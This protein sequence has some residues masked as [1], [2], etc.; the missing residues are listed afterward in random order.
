MKIR[1]IAP[2]GVR[3]TSELKERLQ[4]EAKKNGRSLNAEIVKR[5]EGSLGDI[6]QQSLEHRAD[7]A[8]RIRALEEMLWN[9][10]HEIED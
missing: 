8:D 10:K 1:D 9:L 6:N 7:F 3:M 2:F 5:L 4:E